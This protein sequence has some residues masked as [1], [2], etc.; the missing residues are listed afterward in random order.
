MDKYS[1]SHL[2]DGDLLRGL[3]ALVAQDRGTA[4]ELVAHIAA[5]DERRLYAPKG[6]P[7]MYDYCVKELHLAEDSAI[8]RIRVARVAR[9][10]PMVFAALADGRL[11]LT[12]VFLLSR[13]I[14]A[15]NGAELLAMAAHKSKGEILLLF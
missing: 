4:A 7:C 13:H 2:S 8:K 10:F 14:T 6:Y 15:E 1:L 3:V 12:A 11:N 5:V 9:Q